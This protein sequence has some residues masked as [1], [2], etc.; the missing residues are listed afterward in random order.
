MLGACALCLPA[1]QP[2]RLTTKEIG[3]RTPP[4]FTPRYAGRHVIVR[5]V[6]SE[7][8]F[9][10]VGYALLPFEAERYGAVLE[11]PGDGRELRSFHPGDEIEVQGVVA[12]H[13]GMVTIHPE[14]VRTI[15]QRLPPSPEM[16]P[17]E[18]ILD[19]RHL[20]QEVRTEA[21]IAEI[22]ETTAGPYLSLVT[23]KG[24]FRLLIPRAPGVRSAS[25]ADY[26]VGDKV[27]ATGVALQY[28][29]AP[30]YDRFFELLVVKRS[31]IIRTE[32]SRNMPSPAAIVAAAAALV[33]LALVVWSRER[34]LRSQRERLRRIYQL[35]EQILGA[36]SSE[37]I[38]EEI[39]QSLTALMGISRVKM[40]VYNRATK[41][42]DTISP[43]GNEML[44]V[45]LSAP[46]GGT[47]AGA[48]ACFHYRTLLAIPDIGRSPFPIAT[49]D[50]KNTPKSLMF[51][52]MLA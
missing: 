19:F 45:S 43:G 3:A 18:E 1:E 11:V 9:S 13:A 31:E 35:G 25:L 49:P 5:G 30:P 14:Q 44:S 27:E 20:G 48:V 21:R 28:C 47:H 6:V 16:V 41:A 26:A 23:V 29:P 15:G 51:V 36:S 37:A 12:S 39:S 46:S 52:P 33:V 8:L 17:P 34:R 38:L 24:T 2:L 50:A 10:F 7:P 4:D 42:L 40:Y 22:G 32:K